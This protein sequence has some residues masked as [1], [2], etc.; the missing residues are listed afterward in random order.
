MEYLIDTANIETIRHCNEFYPLAGV[1]TNPTL[2]ARE[3][4]DFFTLI[5][6]IRAILGPDKAMHVQTV[7]ATAEKIVEEAKL[8]RDAV[9]GK[10]FVK[11]PISEEG[12]KATRML[13]E[14]GIGVTMTAIFIPTQAMMAAKAGAS[15]VAPYV[16]RL[17]N[18]LGD[19]V[20]VVG[21]IVELFKTHGL[22]C[23]VLA[24]SF[25]NCEQVH[26][27]A[28]EGCHAVTVSRE[29]FKASISHSMTDVAVAGFTRDWKDLYG[30]KTILDF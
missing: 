6:D 16:N 29:I 1:T 24:A 18:V 3:K 19:G 7:Q 8:L 15:Y 30:D 2:I 12:L 13:R 27:C 17:D 11:I 10:F 25:T 28:M 20:R 9:G 14:L 26:N 23:R 4:S 21:E 22:N 5:K